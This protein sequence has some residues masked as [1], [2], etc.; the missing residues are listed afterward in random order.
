MLS[1]KANESE[2]VCSVPEKKKGASLVKPNKKKETEQHK[3]KVREATC[4]TFSQKK[5]K[6]FK[7]CI[8]Y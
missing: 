2:E 8:E 5:K 1:G 3:G 6:S 4:S 7:V